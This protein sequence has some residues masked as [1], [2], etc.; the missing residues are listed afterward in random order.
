M[1]ARV[2]QYEFG[3]V[4]KEIEELI[5][6]FPSQDNL[7]IVRKMKSIVPEYISMHSDF[8]ILDKA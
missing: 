6:L 7:A 5:A 1:I 3:Y 2:K 8:E 4:S